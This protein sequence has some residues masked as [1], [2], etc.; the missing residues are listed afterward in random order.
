MTSSALLIPYSTRP[1]LTDR[2]WQV[3]C[4]VAAGQGRKRIA[5]DLGLSVRTIDTHLQNLADKLP[6]NGRRA[7]RVTRFVLIAASTAA[8]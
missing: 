4:R 2:E 3:A 7:I 5:A 1:G 6:G 8:V